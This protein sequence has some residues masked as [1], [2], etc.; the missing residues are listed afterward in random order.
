MISS[1]KKVLILTGLGAVC[2]FGLSW[3]RGL[4]SASDARDALRILCDGF[5]LVGAL[6][7]AWG[8]LV[9]CTNGG[10]FDGLTWSVKT[11]IWRIRPDYE[12]VKQSFGEYR[13]QRE[14]KASS[15]K[16][17]LISGAILSAVSL[18]VF[19]AYSLI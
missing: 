1:G 6:M 10:A 5:F 19:A 4:F 2:A 14:K 16:A 18:A 3:G 11:L 15:P 7:L 13:E 17:V 9:W 8:G 12:D